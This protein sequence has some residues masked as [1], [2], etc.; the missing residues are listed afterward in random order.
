MRND[1]ASRAAPVG[2]YFVPVTPGG[3]PVIYRAASLRRPYVG[4]AR[5]IRGADS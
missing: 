1:D 3:T 2:G 4:Q 5:V